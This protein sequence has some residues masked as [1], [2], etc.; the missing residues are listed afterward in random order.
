VNPL[1]LNPRLLQVQIVFVSPLRDPLFDQVRFQF[2]KRTFDGRSSLDI[3]GVLRFLGL[4]IDQEA[5]LGEVNLNRN[6]PRLPTFA[7]FIWEEFESS[8]YARRFAVVQRK[9][10][11]PLEC[12]FAQM[13]QELEAAYEEFCEV[14]RPSFNHA[15]LY[16]SGD[17]S[18]ED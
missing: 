1:S 4:K 18:Y 5:P 9:R 12:S 14:L 15:D 11:E 13:Y 17:E 7:G 3:S 8:I 16:G 6:N 2:D 10:K